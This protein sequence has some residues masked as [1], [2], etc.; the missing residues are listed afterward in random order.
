MSDHHR[1]HFT[2]IALVAGIIGLPILLWHSPLLQPDG[3]DTRMTL[4]GPV[5]SPAPP[6]G[7]EK[8]IRLV[9]DNIDVDM[10][11]FNRLYEEEF[12][13]DILLDDK[14]AVE[15][16]VILEDREQSTPFY[17]WEDGIRKS[18]FNFINKDVYKGRKVIG[19]VKDILVQR[20]HPELDGLA[21][22][23]LYL[24]YSG[25]EKTANGDNIYEIA[26]FD[27]VVMEQG[28]DNFHVTINDAEKPQQNFHY[29]DLERHP[30]L[31]SLKMLQAGK[32]MDT[33]NRIIGVI[34]AVTYDKALAREV[35]VK[36]DNTILN[37]P[38][39][40]N[41][42]A[43]PFTEI[44]LRPNQDAVDVMFTNTQIRAIAAAAE[45]TEQ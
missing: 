24:V 40:E 31:I 42:F 15:A 3:P 35:I 43:I 7:A 44:D 18:F 5:P 1:H 29:S 6:S 37:L 36:L 9:L 4:S 34:Y 19:Q 13:R 38:E 22:T 27:Y 33:Q 41:F 23:A 25:D 14:A 45:K 30:D 17:A 32:A 39:G 8:E 10:R 28:N 2:K 26:P 20:Y 21:G 11:E 12:F 16:P